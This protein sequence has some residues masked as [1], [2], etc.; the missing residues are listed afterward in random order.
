MTTG[1]LSAERERI[2]FLHDRLDRERTAAQAELDAALRDSHEQRWHRE[3]AVR[4]LSDQVSRLKVAGDGLCFGRIDT[5]DERTYV[6]R[7]GLFDTENDYEPLLTD[8]RAPTA[9]PFYTATAANPEGVVLRRHFHTKGRHLESFHDGELQ[10][11]SKALLD[12]LNA[13]RSDTMRDTVATIQAEQDEVIRL[14]HRGVLVIEGGPGT[15]KTAVALH[16]VAYLLY[17]VY[18]TPIC[19]TRPTFK[20]KV[21]SHNRNLTA[22]TPTCTGGTRPTQVF[23]HG[24]RRYTSARRGVGVWTVLCGA[25]L[26]RSRPVEIAWSALSSAAMR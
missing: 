19:G 11:T 2:A 25:N 18:Q 4:T 8:W 7:I 5:A 24:H 16:R 9:R 23:W 13:P 10:F 17:T 20:V 21:G 14:P 15:G 26:Q 12:A 1:E 22:H 3:V 6:G